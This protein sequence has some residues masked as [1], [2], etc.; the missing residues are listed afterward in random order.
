MKQRKRKGDIKTRQKRRA[1]DIQSS[2]SVYNRIVAFLRAVD[3][4]II[5]FLILL[6]TFLFFGANIKLNM[7]TEWPARFQI[8]HM[9]PDARLYYSIAENIVDGTG[10]FDTYRKKEIMP[11]VGHPLLLVIFC[12][13][14]GLSPAEFTWVFLFVSFVF[15]GLG[16]RIYTK[17]NVCVFLAL[18]LYGSF[19]GYIRWLSGNVEASIVLSHTILIFSMVYLYRSKFKIVSAVIGGI[20]LAVNLLIR[21]LYLFP[22][23]LCFLIVLGFALYHH[24]R[25]REVALS[26][27]VKGWLILIIIAEAIMLS[28]YFYSRIKYKDSRLV[29]GTYGAWPLYTANNIYIPP[30]EKFKGGNYPYPQEFIRM[31]NTLVSKD[32]SGISWQER[33][34]ILMAKVINY[35]KEHPRRAFS[36]WWW[37]FRQFIG[38]RSGEFSW[39]K[40]LTVF[41]SFSVV[42]LFI[43]I[44]IRVIF[45]LRP[46]KGKV[47]LI[48]SLGLLTAG[49][50][51]AYAAIHALFVYREF[52]YVACAIPFLVAA[53]IIIMYEIGPL[54]RLLFFPTKTIKK[55]A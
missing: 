36:G 45:A 55:G 1:A 10:Y 40:P 20:V 53:D 31:Q 23:H 38:I 37:R 9:N 25:K 41:H 17:S 5:V 6:I 11:T 46:K 14:G 47:P 50:F 7:K 15:L 54:L 43:L 35:W 18:W 39:R 28:T 42:V 3:R 26:S 27:F 13:A 34:K 32:Y 21:P 52:R 33:K 22:M 30:E 4:N 29:T 51:L 2:L 12:V 24:F 16:V 44:L 48:N 49:L 19:L 8:E